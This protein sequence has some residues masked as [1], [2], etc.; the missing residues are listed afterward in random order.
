MIAGL[1]LAANVAY[2]EPPQDLGPAPP[3]AVE[4]GFDVVVLRPLGFVALLVSSAAFIPVALI[5]SP[6]GRDSLEMALDL[7][8]VTPSNDVFGRRLGAF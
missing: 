3:N 1:F 5:T 2:A 4:I 7:F 6:G 8:V